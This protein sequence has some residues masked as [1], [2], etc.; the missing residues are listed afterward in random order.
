[1][2]IKNMIVKKAEVDLGI[3]IKW[4]NM[5]QKNNLPTLVKIVYWIFKILKQD[6][7]KFLKDTQN[8]NQ[9]LMIKDLIQ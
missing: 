2:I 4:S 5:S 9:K 3:N 8:L 7:L 6:F 1:M